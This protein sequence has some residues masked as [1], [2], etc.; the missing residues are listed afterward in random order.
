MTTITEITDRKPWDTITH[1]SENFKVEAPRSGK[2]ITV[3]L[4]NGREAR[5]FDT[6]AEALAWIEEAEGAGYPAL[7]AAARAR[8]EAEKAAKAAAE[9][10]ARPVAQATRS[11]GC[12]YCGLPLRR[13]VCVECGTEI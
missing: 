1:T 4:H 7:W 13:G 12:H 8:R 10:Q 11:A 9:A 5:D 2:Y 6:I 3:S